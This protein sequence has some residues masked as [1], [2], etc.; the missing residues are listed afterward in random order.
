MS[1]KTDVKKII[2]SLSPN[3][4]KILPYLNES[5]DNICRK[6]NIDKV[7]I[8]RSLNYLQNKKILL[9]SYGKKIMVDAGVNGAL[10]RKKGLPE[11]RL[12][13]LLGEKRIVGIKEA[14]KETKLSDDELK[15]SIGALKKKSMI[16]IKN[17]RIILSTGSEGVSKKIPEE[18]FLDSL[19]LDYDLLSEEQKSNLKFLQ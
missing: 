17:D 10:Y 2:E 14:Q 4:R 19:P 5:I 8:M 1:Q 6:S 13:N 18:I 7:S 9:L 16:E 15:A 3:E 11:R 12:M